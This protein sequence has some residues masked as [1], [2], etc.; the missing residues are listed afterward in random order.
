MT[1][2][3][4]LHGVKVL[5]VDDE[6]DILETLVDL[7][8]MCIV[9]TADD[10]ESGKKFLE[11]KTYETA[12]FDIMGVNGYK[13][14]SIANINGIPALMLTAHALSPLNLVKSIKSGARAYLPKDRIVDIADFLS[15]FLESYKQGIKKSGNWFAKLKPFFD[16]KFG[17]D[18]REKDKDFWSDFDRQSVV[19]RDELG[20]I[21]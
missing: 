13:L 1:E 7:L 14:L 4:I 3:K 10:F 5:V 12:I 2:T 21:L 8:D 18:W 19:T 9:D 15:D 16:R 11:E 20:R 6:K 17:P